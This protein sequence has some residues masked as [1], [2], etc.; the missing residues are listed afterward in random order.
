M[1]RRDPEAIVSRVQ[2]GSIAEDLGLQPGDR[3]V[4]INGHVLHDLI[5]YRFFSEEEELEILVRRGDE[6]ALFEVERDYG[7]ELGIEFEDALFDGIRSCVNNCS[8]CFIKGMPPGMRRSLYVRD[9]DYRLGFL[10]GSFIT[11][12][13]LSEEDWGRIGE[14]ALSPLYV[15]VHATD[16]GLRRRLLG[17]PNAPDILPQLRRLRDLG[18]QVHTQVV[19]TPGENDGENLDRTVAD[20]AE[21]WPSVRSV[22]VVPIGLTRFHRACVDSVGSYTGQDAGPLI[23]HLQAWQ[24]EYRRRF[25]LGWVYASDEWYL[26]ADRTP[27]PARSYDGFAQI[28]NGVGLV[29]QLLDDWATTTRRRNVR[30]TGPLVLVCGA[31]IAPTL[32]R[33]AGE[34]AEK[35]GQPVRVLPVRNQFFGER[36]SVSG[37]LTG[38]DVREAIEKGAETGETVFLPRAMFDADGQLTLDGMTLAELQEGLAARLAVAGRLS[39]VIRQLASEKQKSQR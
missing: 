25:G 3:I 23:D 30:S 26:L 27:P 9:D 34:V 13:N 5:D 2:A 19:L 36:V 37:L 17:N 22:G 35:I 14:Q 18:I 15:S 28:E 12:S 31:L 16:S 33:L 20:L 21:L 4:S 39:E 7:V 11:L 8:F 6:E 38:K 1:T 29:R 32:T 24:S 10:A